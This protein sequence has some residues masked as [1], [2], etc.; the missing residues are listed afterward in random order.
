MLT[1]GI[2]NIKPIK[3]EYNTNKNNLILYLDRL[4]DIDERIFENME[5]HITENL[6]VCNDV[7]FRLVPKNR[8][9]LIE[10]IENYKWYLFY[11]IYKKCRGLKTIL[12]DFDFEV[13][14]NNS[15]IINVPVGI[16]DILLDRKVDL[17]LNQVLKNEFSIETQILIKTKEMNFEIENELNIIDFEKHKDITE[18]KEETHKVDKKTEVNDD[19]KKVVFGK[20]INIDPTPISQIKTGEKVCIE[21]EVINIESKESKNGT[22]LIYKFYITDY[23]NST[24]AKCIIKKDKD[25]LSIIKKGSYIKIFGN[26]E[27]DDYEKTISIVAKDI[28]FSKKIERLDNSTQKRVELHCHTKMSSMDAVSSVEDI[29]KTAATWGHKAIAITDHGVVQAYPE[30]QN[31]QKAFKDKPIKIIYGMECYLVDD[32]IP[33]VYFADENQTLD[34]TFVVF[35][36]ETTGFDAHKDK[37]IEIGAVKVKNNQIVDKFSTFINPN[38]K[39]PKKII[40]LTSI[41][42][43]MLVDAPQIEEVI[44]NFFEF[45]KDSILV[46]HN[47][48]FD[49]GFIKQAFIQNNLKFDFT[50]IDTLEL[51]RRLLKELNSHKLNKVAQHL[52]IEL[53]SHHRAVDD[54]QATAN[55]FIEFVNR[56]KSKGYNRLSEINNLEKSNKDISKLN[57]YHATIL[58]K[59]Y[60]GLYNLYKLTSISHLEFFYKR[61]RIPKSLLTQ[62]KEG[63]IVGSACEAGELFRAFIEGK[64]EYEIEKISRFYDYFEIMPVINNSFLVREGYIENFDALREINKKIYALGKKTGKLVVA[65]SDAH[66]INK[67]EKIFRQILKHS[68]GYNDVDND[69]DLYLRTTDEMI[70]EFSYL[71][72]KECFEVVVEN[73]NKI[74]DMIENIKPIP[75]ETFPPKIEGAE[76]T[77][78]QMTMSKAHEIY[79]ENLPKVV[80]E[81]LEKELNSIIKNGFSVM[82]LIAQKL[83]SKSLSDGYLVGSRGSVGSSLVA[84]MCGITEVNPLPPHYVCPNC[85]YSEFILDGSIGSGFDLPDKGCP[86]CKTKLKKD[87]HDIPFETFL[88]FDGDKEPDI[89]LNFSG[90][91]QPIAHKYTEELFGQGHVFRAG[92]ISTVAEKT[93][94]GYVLKY[95]EEKGKNFHPAEI[96]RLS[97]GCSGV[98]RTTGQHPGGLMIVPKDKEI[99]EFTPIQRPADAEDASVITTHFDYHAISGRLLK[100]DILGHDDPTVIRM[101]QDLTGVNP[102]EIPLDDKKTMSLFT[103]TEALGISPEDIDCEIGTFGIPEFGTRFVRQMLIET[104]PKTFSELIRISGL[105]HGEDVWLNNAQ[106][107]VKNNITTLKDVISTR[108]DIMVYLI[109]KNVPP[110]DSFRI[111]EQVRKGK[112]LSKD[113]ENLLKQYNVPDW[114]IESCKKIKYMFPKA[115]AAAYVMMAFRIAYFKV[116]YKEAFYAT[117]FTVRADEFDYSTIMQGRELIREKIRDLENRIGNLSQKEKGLLTILEI[118]NEMLARGLKFYPVDIDESDA[119]MFKIKDDGLLVPLN[120]L[121]N[122]GSAAAKNIQEARKEGKFLSIEDLQRRTKVNKQVLEI[123]KQYKILKDIPETSQ[124]SFI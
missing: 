91:Y 76:D 116:Y 15:L 14:N 120:A 66:Y 107:L 122:V 101:L 18:H 82:Y 47:A 52:N 48:Q 10:V 113:D 67:E 37:I 114:Y 72:E 8:Y 71:G 124:L 16:K 95:A 92:T 56:L 49:I 68:Q 99:Y 45:C 12:K 88:G 78:M 29:I 40:E 109:Y 87:G 86:N 70:E 28:N 62:Y 6:K 93:A 102:K 83:V 61:P 75:D 98:K 80:S 79:G 105:S 111:M 81:R 22:H 42:D 84:T 74:A 77:I 24:F 63:L 38:M 118:A 31:T 33:I 97:N 103:S 69:P 34:D 110:K 50:F 58:V 108:D 3:I 19:E 35:D 25:T 53:I 30:A 13:Q 89:D 39:L 1:E 100:L 23:K 59:N 21:G 36:V 64:S 43:N 51:S 44:V 32:G 73:T 60:Q 85:K 104:K 4:N 2:L 11:K 117:Y 121:P 106:E 20:K 5:L 112:G 27:F 9:V 57:S 119:T 7:E 65:T 26:V 46:A 94:I 17:L 123:F 54:A 115:H 41:D 96:F 90:E 55:I